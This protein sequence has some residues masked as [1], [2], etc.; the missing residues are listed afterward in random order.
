MTTEIETGI[1]FLQAT[2]HQRLPAN[3]Q[4]ERDKTDSPSEHNP[5]DTLIWD[6]EPPEQGDNNA[7]S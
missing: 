3:L 1:R 5:V 6:F 7:C 2:D 4:K